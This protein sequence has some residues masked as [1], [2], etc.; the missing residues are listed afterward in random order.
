MIRNLAGQTA[1]GQVI[2]ATT[3]A[4]FSGTVTVYVSLDGSTATIGSVGS[5]L[6][7]DVGGGLFT[8]FPTAG[9]TDGALVS[10]QFRGTGAITTVVEYPTLTLAQQSAASAGTGSFATTANT[11][12]TG[13][14]Q[15]LGVVDPEETPTA[16]MLADGLRR[17]NMMMGSWTTQSL[18]IPTVNREVFDM[19]AD[20]GGPD[21]PYTIG[22]GGD[23][24]TTRPLTLEGAGLLLNASDPPVE[25]PLAV[26]TDDAYQLTQI[27]DLSNVLPTQV[28][29]NPTFAGGLGTIILWPVPNTASNSLVLYRKYQLGLF[30]SATAGYD[31][32]EGAAE[33][34]EYQ[35]ALRL[36]GTWNRGRV[37]DDVREIARTSFSTFKR[38]NY[39]LVDLPQ[40]PI[41]SNRRFGY[42]I[43]TGTG[44]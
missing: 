12:I 37:P 36:A 43:Q 28:Y 17:L 5:G 40:D 38:S 14:L 11:I 7:T 4:A 6:A 39:K 31:L 44:S 1:Q 10:F 19:T 30:T 29:Y 21:D 15:L 27:K 32:P 33:P 18:T 9:E 41:L 25:I 16:A 8:Y 34:I 23:F 13:A 2:N 3:G 42:N 35:L 24:D 22:P 20:K 26:I